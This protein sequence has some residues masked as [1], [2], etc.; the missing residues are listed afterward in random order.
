M[1]HPGTARPACASSSVL[2]ELD[3]PD[4]D[5]VRNRPV[6]PEPSRPPRVCIY[7]ED[8]DYYRDAVRRGGGEPARLEEADALFFM[9]A[10]LDALK[11]MLLHNIKWVSIPWAGTD[12]VVDSG[13]HAGR[14]WS[15]GRGLYGD[16]VAEHALALMLAGTKRID[17]AARERRWDFIEGDR[18]LVSGQSA[19]VIGA[20]DVGL[21]L[22][23][24]LS[25]LG[26]RVTVLARTPRSVQGADRVI[27]RSELH[28]V[29][30]DCRYVFLAV[31]LT[32][33]TRHIIGE[34]ELALL[35]RDAWLVNVARGGHVDT[36]ALV[37][38]L[39]Q[40]AIAGAALDVVEPEPLPANHPLWR[41][42]RV[43][44][45]PHVGVTWSMAREGLAR[46]L[47][48]NVRRFRRG[49]RLVGQFP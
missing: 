35:P 24:R 27:A 41:M 26:L 39:R 12:A 18:P 46:R 48:E 43:I 15:C 7:A 4:D 13:L 19:L 14:L 17:I 10:D 6:T 42:D 31:A 21:A 36:E 8:G 44:I 3:R 34:V 32:S 20:G 40:N 29:L 9:S 33:E 22:V 28:E 38:A 16:H 49:A 47:E 1:P 25:A 23:N 5:S 2:G 37:A 30:P 45:T 11:R